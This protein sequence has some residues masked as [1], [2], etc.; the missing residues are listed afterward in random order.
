MDLAGKKHSVGFL[1]QKQA[2]AILSH[3]LRIWRKGLL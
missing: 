3:L 2:R 1:D